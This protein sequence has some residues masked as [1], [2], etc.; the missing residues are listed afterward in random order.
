LVKSADI[1]VDE[2]S[3][4]TDMNAITEA[5]AARLSLTSQKGFAS[6]DMEKAA[7]QRMRGTMACQIDGK[8]GHLIPVE[9]CSSHRQTSGHL[10]AM[11]PE[12]G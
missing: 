9:S 4:G 8:S 2:G 1:P 3:G 10:P 5:P 11:A 6:I 12:M 7:P